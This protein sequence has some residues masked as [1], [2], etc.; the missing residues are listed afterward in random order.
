[1]DAVREL[2]VANRIFVLFVYGLIFF[3]MGLAIFLQARHH[4]RLRLAR[5]LRWLAVFGILHGLNEWGYIFIPIQAATDPNVDI[6]QLRTV[7]LVLLIGSF[8][9]LFWFGAVTLEEKWPWLPRLVLAVCA[10]YLVW[11]CIAGLQGMADWHLNARVIARY[12]LALPGALL[13]AYG[14][15]YQAVTYVAPLKVP[16]IYRMLQVSG[17]VLVAYALVAGVVVSPAPFFPASVI[18]RAWLEET[19]GIQVEVLRSLVGLALTIAIIRALELFDIEV[20]RLIEHMEAERIQAAE[21]ERIGQEIHDGAIQGVYSASLILESAQPLLPADS[22]AAR[23]V[24]QARSVLSA[25]NTDLRSYMVSLR[26][27]SSAEP[28]VPSLHHLI[29]DPRFAGLLAIELSV[30]EEPSL[31]PVQ[32][33]QIVAIVQESLS[34][35]LRHARA[36]RVWIRIA[37]SM[38]TVT[39]TIEDDG[40]GFVAD[41]ETAGYGLRSMRDRARLIGGALDVISTPGS[42]T[43]VRLRLPEEKG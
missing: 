8:M 18:N 29:H 4:S 11:V 26:T 27:Q 39:L 5:D 28:L 6:S 10:G 33:V 25:V 41:D 32:V 42:G 1:M 9:A 3:V 36:H 38:E 21:R 12:A 31:T 19:T 15:R 17:A 16:H 37:R 43:K 40:R 34:N 13:A 7:Q 20:D 23:R 24:Q 35:I 22:G 2:L 14:L 30:D